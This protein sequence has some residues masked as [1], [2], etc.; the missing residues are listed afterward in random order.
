M[1]LLDGKKHKRHRSDVI[2]PAVKY[3]MKE[4]ERT[5]ENKK[6]EPSA[7]KSAEP[8]NN[9]FA[10]F[11]NM[12]TLTKQ[13]ASELWAEKM[14]KRMID[15]ATQ[16]EDALTLGEFYTSIGILNQDFCALAA[17]YPLL[18]KALDYTRQVIGDRREKGMLTRKFDSGSVAYM[19]PAYDPMWKE[20][21]AWRASLKQPAEGSN[22]IRMQYV[23]IPEIR[24]ENGK[25]GSNNEA[26]AVKP[27]NVGQIT[28][29]SSGE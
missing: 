18:Q 11:Y 21:V 14:S 10:E 5:G 26:K 6:V 1:S 12:N 8:K 3:V 29:D 19:M 17:K 23:V 28:E 2:D 25:L 7:L 27:A 24:A 4:R 16:N 9:T 20:I 15:W 22:N 13:V